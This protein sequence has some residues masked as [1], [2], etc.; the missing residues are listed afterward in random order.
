[1]TAL[2]VIVPEPI[3]A[4]I[5][6]GEVIDRY[7]NP[8]DVFDDVHLLLLNDDRPSSKALERLTGRATVH[9]H[10]LPPP[11]HALVR[12]L[13]FRPW[14]LRSWAERGVEIARLVEPSLTRCYGAGLNAYLAREVR[15][16]L[17]VPYL[18]SL[19]VNP[20][21]DLR[22]GS[23]ALRTRIA[24]PFHAA[25]ERDVLRDAD[26][27]LPVY[28]PIVPYLESIGVSR[29]QVAYNMINASNLR[30]KQDY[31][32]RG[33][34]RV[35][36]VG[37]QFH[38]KD[39]SQLIRAVAELPDVHLNLVGQGERHHALRKLVADLD[40]QDRVTFDV[41]LAND[42]LCCR[43]PEFDVFAVHSQYWELSKAMLEALLT[44]LPMVVNRRAGPMIPELTDDLCV[45][46]ENSAAGYLRALQQL[47]T[48]DDARRAL[49]SRAADVSH[50][51][52]GPDRTEAVFADVYRS[53]LHGAQPAAPERG[54][55]G[56]AP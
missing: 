52:W 54:G 39:P 45:Y 25:L 17:G 56:A 30:R 48:D 24:G 16:R 33:P 36:S 50:A 47:A 41:A 28:E 5:A 20:A 51:R 11:P 46:V 4:W 6:K 53:F 29:Y 19:H 8:G 10:H 35:L 49:G 55:A 1:M 2:L 9:L 31:G 22:G 26:L 27:V 3:S 44:G 7:Y 34:M 32:L 23:P 13:G 38:A 40:V 12:T 21:E 37:R 18:V 42:E 14:L 43:L 15:R